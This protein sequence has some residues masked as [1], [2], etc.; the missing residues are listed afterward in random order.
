MLHRPVELAPQTGQVGTRTHLCGFG[1]YR[2]LALI[3]AL[4]RCK[5][6]HLQLGSYRPSS[7]SVPAVAK[8]FSYPLCVEGTF[9]IDATEGVRSEII[10]LCLCEVRWKV[11]AAVRVVIGKRGGHSRDRDSEAHSRLNR[12]S[13]ILLATLDCLAKR[14]I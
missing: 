7:E 12:Q 10:A 1:A 3:E 5:C 13:P 6:V 2:M 8:E 4:G 14:S 9:S 11:F